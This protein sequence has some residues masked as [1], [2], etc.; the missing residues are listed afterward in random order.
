MEVGLERKTGEII[1]CFYYEIEELAKQI[2]K[3]YCCKSKE[4]L[5]QFLAFSKNYTHFSPYFDFVIGVLGYH[6][7]NPFFEANKILW[8]DPKTHAFYRKMYVPSYKDYLPCQLNREYFHFSSDN[9]LQINTSLE[10]S[11]KIYV[12]EDGIKFAPPK[13]KWE[14]ARQLLN[15]KIIQDKELCEEVEQQKLENQ[16]E[17]EI[18]SRYVPLTEINTFEAQREFFIQIH[19]Y[20]EPQLFRLVRK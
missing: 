8:G 3:E 9:D 18:L 10:E 7:R 13:S 5:E 20:E 14:L 11:S 6:L 4:N 1:Y 12:N 16:E 17:H 19:D 15:L 2:T